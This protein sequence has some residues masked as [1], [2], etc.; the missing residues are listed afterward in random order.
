M[1][2]EN[3]N[4][5]KY[6]CLFFL[7]LHSRPRVVLNFSC[8]LLFFLRKSC[9]C[10]EP[11]PAQLQTEM[12]SDTEDEDEPVRLPVL[13]PPLSHLPCLLSSLLIGYNLWS[14]EA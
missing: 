9:D 12:N 11:F 6:P 8:N 7:L 2:K 3:R 5:I 4:S 10:T 13:Y 14:R 1:I